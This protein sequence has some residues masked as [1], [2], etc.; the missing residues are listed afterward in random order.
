MKAIQIQPDIYWVGAVDWAVRDFHGYVTPKG[1]SYNNYLILDENI[2]LVDTVK[3]PFSKV[4]IDNISSIVDPSKIAY[5]VMNHIEPDHA[6]SIDK[7]MTLSPDA[8]IYISEKGKK[9]LER[10]F[11]VSKWSI[12]T[13][14]TGDTLKTGKYTLL[15]LETPMLHWP[16]SMMTYV[17]ETKLLISQDAFGQHIATA[18]RFND[19]FIECASHAELEDAVIDYYANILMPFGQLIKRKVDEITKLGLE[20]EMIAPDH[21]IIWRKNASDIIQQYLDLAGGKASL[22]VAVIYDTMWHSTE[23]MTLPITQGVKDEGVECNVIKLR[24]TPMSAAIKEFWKARGCLIGSPTLNNILYPSV[25][26]FLTYLRGLRPRNRMMGAFG[27]Y[28]WGGGAVKDAYEEFKKMKLEVYEPGLQ[29]LYKPSME[30][31]QKCYEFGQGFARQ[32]KEYHARF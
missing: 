9:G 21:G 20:I 15:F 16:D 27:S 32:V 6:S 28:G 13:V 17:K 31:E 23:L 30:D 22:A 11:D 26:E 5:I 4:T 14:K 12:Q 1:T 18:A 25:A 29:V 10:H 8:I 3:Y 24:A 19:E 2:T 7:I